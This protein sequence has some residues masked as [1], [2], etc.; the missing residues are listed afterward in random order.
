[1]KS[2]KASATRAR[3]MYFDE[4]DKSGDG[5]NGTARGG[6]RVYARPGWTVRRDRQAGL[7]LGIR[8]AVVELPVAARR[9]ARSVNAI[10]NGG[11]R[12]M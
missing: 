10:V 1:M 3:S 9:P 4:F 2:L 6:A 11:D 7:G 12:R 8:G 5:V